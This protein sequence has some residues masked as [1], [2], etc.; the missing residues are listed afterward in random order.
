MIQIDEGNI[1]S[2]SVDIL[3]T[4]QK[5]RLEYLKEFA[6]LTDKEKFLHNKVL[7][8]NKNAWYWNFFRKM[9]EDC[10]YFKY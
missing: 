8:Q 7:P 9:D 6:K 3:K 1:N 5:S 4:N 2:S 10:R